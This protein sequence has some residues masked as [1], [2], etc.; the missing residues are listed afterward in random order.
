MIEKKNLRNVNTIGTDVTPV[1]TIYVKRI[2]GCE[3]L[4]Y[5]PPI[6]T[7]SPDLEI[8]QG[9]AVDKTDNE[10]TFKTTTAHDANINMKTHYLNGN[11]TNA[12]LRFPGGGVNGEFSNQLTV[13]GAIN[14]DRTGGH[15]LIAEESIR[16]NGSYYAGADQGVTGSSPF[17]NGLR[18]GVSGLEYQAGSITVK[19]GIVIGLIQGTSWSPVPSV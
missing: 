13:K 14:A 15:S 9:M 3:N 8:F 11:G 17:I 10:F 16:A 7:I 1:D 4:S 18:F 6:I 12:G 19:D 2:I 5:K